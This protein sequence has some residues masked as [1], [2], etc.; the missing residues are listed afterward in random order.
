MISSNRLTLV[1]PILPPARG[2]WDTYDI[3]H[4]VVQKVLTR[5][6]TVIHL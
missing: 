1:A 6:T 5:K 3:T 2:T 4:N